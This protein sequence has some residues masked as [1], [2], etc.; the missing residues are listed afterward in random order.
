M[1]ATIS[2]ELRTPL[3]SIKGFA[4]TLLAKDVIWDQERWESFVTIIDEEASKLNELVEQVL[5]V[6]RLQ[7]GALSIHVE[8]SKLSSV[9][10]Q[11]L[12]DLQ[13]HLAEHQLIV[14]LPP[15]LPPVLIDQR[16]ITQVLVNLVANAAKY[17]PNG[18]LIVLTA[19]VQPDAVEMWVA[20]EG[21]GIPKAEREQVFE[22]FYQSNGGLRKRAGTGMGLAICKGLIEQHGGKIWIEDR[23]PPA[24]PSVLPCRLLNSYPSSPSISS[25]NKMTPRTLPFELWKSGVQ[26]TLH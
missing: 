14:E 13:T 4:S 26:V 15:D 11:A 7:A 21:V 18:T 12:Q 23:D 25:I 9:V 19:S 6:S 17:S 3:A 10:E 1:L 5:D 16:R 20:D 8:P 2:H 24:P 22:A